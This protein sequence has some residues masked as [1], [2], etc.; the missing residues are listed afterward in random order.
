MPG[1]T[2]IRQS[3]YFAVDNDRTHNPGRLGTTGDCNQSDGRWRSL[4]TPGPCMIAESVGMT[5]V[6][7][8]HVDRLVPAVIHHPE[9]RGPTRAD[10]RK[11]ERRLC[12]ENA[13]ASSPRRSG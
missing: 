12:P 9:Q 2:H 1:Q 8:Q 6:A 13:S 11:S 4:E 10:V 3:E 7:A 5:D